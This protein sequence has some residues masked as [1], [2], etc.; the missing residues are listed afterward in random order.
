[1]S[2]Q[3]PRIEVSV[4]TQRL[5]LWDGQRLVAG[6]PCSTSKFGLGFTEGSQKTPLGAFR[7]GEKHGDGAPAGT[8]F[9]SRQ[10]VGLWTPGMDTT[11]DLVLSR[12]L[13]LDGL[14]KRNANTRARYIYIHGTNDERAIGRPASHGCVRLRNAD[15]IALYERVP[16]GTPVWIVE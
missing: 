5:A 15:M 7:V 1:M 8:I 13:W 4:A 6:W 2:L 3:H 14:E 16:A 12:I 10:P 9:K 11:G